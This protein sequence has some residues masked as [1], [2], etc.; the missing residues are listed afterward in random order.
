V[1]YPR[2][3]TSASVMGMRRAID[4]LLEGVETGLPPDRPDLS[5]SFEELNSLLGLDEIQEIEARYLTQ[6]DLARKYRG[7]GS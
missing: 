6:D 1:I 5:V 4:T 3:L 7:A 2:M